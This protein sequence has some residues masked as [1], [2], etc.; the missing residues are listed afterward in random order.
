MQLGAVEAGG[1]ELEQLHFPRQLQH[2]EEDVDQ[3]VEETPAEAGQGVVIGVAAGGQ[4]A[5]GERV[6]SGAVNLAA[7]KGAVT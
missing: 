5:Q 4:V 2:L 7:G 6:V 3:L 1:A